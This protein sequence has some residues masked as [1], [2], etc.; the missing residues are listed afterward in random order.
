MENLMKILKNKKVVGAAVG[1]GFAVAAAFGY[2]VSPEIQDS[3]SM[4]IFAIVGN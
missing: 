2:S 3:V 1:L 4:V